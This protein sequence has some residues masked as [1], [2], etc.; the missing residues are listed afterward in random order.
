MTAYFKM[1]TLFFTISITYNILLKPQKATLI[2][3]LWEK[4]QKEGFR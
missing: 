4:Y 2:M 1:I 3:T